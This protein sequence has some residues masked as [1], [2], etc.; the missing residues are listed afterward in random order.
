MRIIDVME[1]YPT[2]EPIERET[3]RFHRKIIIII[4]VNCMTYAYHVKTQ[5]VVHCIFVFQMSQSAKQT[6]S[7]IK[8]DV[9]NCDED[10]RYN[11]VLAVVKTSPLPL[12]YECILC[13]V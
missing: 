1:R 5:P 11:F 7:G 13:Y 4:N 9:R 6:A 10:Q 8:V 3:S 2:Q 12:H